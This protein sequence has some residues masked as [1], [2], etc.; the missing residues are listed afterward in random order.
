MRGNSSDITIRIKM[1]FYECHRFTING[2]ERAFVVSRRQPFWQLIKSQHCV[3]AHM[4][5][6]VPTKAL[7]AKGEKL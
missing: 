7:A 5:D 6:T 3:V 4:R 2:D 1:I